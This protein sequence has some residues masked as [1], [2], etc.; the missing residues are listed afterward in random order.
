VAGGAAI[1][2]AQSDRV[3]TA[4]AAMLATASDASF[5]QPKLL[6]LVLVTAVVGPM[7]AVL[8]MGA[9][10]EMIAHLRRQL[11]A[12]CVGYLVEAAGR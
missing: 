6:S 4:V 8:E 10:P 2:K 3:S 5:E 11:T 1:V 12:L 7:Q 9:N